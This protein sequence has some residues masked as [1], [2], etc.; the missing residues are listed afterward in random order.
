M[1]FPE[2][3][4]RVVAVAEIVVGER[5]RH[6][7]GDVDALAANIKKDRLLHDIVLSP[8]MRLVAGYRRL[9]AVKRL[10]WR[11]VEVKIVHSLD[12]LNK[13]FEAEKDENEYR[14]PYT[15]V[16]AQKLQDRLMDILRPSAERAKRSG[17]S[18]DGKA[19][20]RGRT[21]D[22]KNHTKSSSKVSVPDRNSR[23]AKAKAAK[24]TGYSHTTLA[25]VEEIVKAAKADPE[26]FGHLISK[27]DRT[28]AK[29]NAAY[30]EFKR[31]EHEK[32]TE[33]AVEELKDV[34]ISAVADLRVC[35]MQELLP[36]LHDVD[37]IITDPPYP[38]EFLPLYG[39]LA[40]LA[41]D[42]L[43]PHGMLAVMCGQSY[44]PEIFDLMARHIPYRWTM[45]YLTP[46]GQSVQLWG[47][48]VNTFWKP[49]LV[50]GPSKEVEWLGDVVKSSVN[51]NDK[52]FHDWGQSE[53]GMTALIEALTE[54][55][56]L[57]CDPF[58][59]AGTTGV[60]ALALGR[61]F[62]GCDVDGV[63]VDTA[64]VRMIRQ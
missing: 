37:A 1:D 12:D 43:A 64:R 7:L 63:H 56:Q 58:L 27:L 40:R 48:K 16:E 57:V 38:E 35:S 60:V 33:A 23:M 54:P 25:K 55:R 42:C 50:F 9:E 17:K 59:G 53:S 18:E 2:S 13:E 46:G 14:V 61:R 34:D 19:G 24:P 26:T 49:I 5:C 45:A 36:T 51:D 28:D 32:E 29:V 21:K 52:R 11:E 41:A 30:K 22:G 39:E 8:G 10:G 6:N 4:H 47:R 15:P 44:L 20:G 62:V 3:E 31:L